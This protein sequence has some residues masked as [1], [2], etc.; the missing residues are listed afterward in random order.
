MTA[1]KDH[2][3]DAKSA[4][5]LYVCTPLPFNYHRT[6]PGEV[7]IV[8]FATTIRDR[9]IAT[10]QGSA[11]TIDQARSTCVLRMAASAHVHYKTHNKAHVTPLAAF[12]FPQSLKA[13]EL[14]A[15]LK[16]LYLLA[17]D[18]INKEKGKPL[19]WIH[20]QQGCIALVDAWLTG[21]NSKLPRY[22]SIMLPHNVHERKSRSHGSLLDRSDGNHAE[23]SD[24]ANLTVRISTHADQTEPEDVSVEAVK[25]KMGNAIV[26]YIQAQE[27]CGAGKRFPDKSWFRCESVRDTADIPYFVLECMSTTKDRVSLP[28]TVFAV[29]D[30]LL[31][32]VDPPMEL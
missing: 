24:K 25:T 31:E 27:A 20:N 19:D 23:T 10:K 4:P 1:D 18:E 21:F 2:A 5:L 16:S 30:P 8:M 7:T 12:S 13:P 28:F 3:G 11:A 6:R 14:D 29:P 26:V 9:G 22:Q 32:G 17:G 15:A